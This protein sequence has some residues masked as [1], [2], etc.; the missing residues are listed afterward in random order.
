MTRGRREAE[1]HRRRPQGRSSPCP[2]VVP[3][4]MSRWARAAA[5]SGQIR[6][7]QTSRSRRPSTSTGRRRVRPARRGRRRRGRAWAARRPPR[8]PL[9]RYPTPSCDA[10]P[11]SATV[12][13]RCAVGAARAVGKVWPRG[14]LGRCS[15]PAPWRRTGS[16]TGWGGACTRSRPG[17]VRR[18]A[19]CGLYAAR[20]RDTHACEDP[21]SLPR[22]AWHN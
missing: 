3:P 11:A 12:A 17:R 13:L 15:W 14:L 5:D 22:E 9:R 1:A 19:L 16:R 8:A 6:L 18:L 7:R 4:S 21:P 10:C 2:C 20:L